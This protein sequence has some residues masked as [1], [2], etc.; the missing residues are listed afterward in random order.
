MLLKSP[1][2][3]S[4]FE[5]DGTLTVSGMTEDDAYITINVDGKPVL[6]QKTLK[7]IKATMGEEGDFS[8]DI[9]IGKG[10]YKKEVEVIVSDEIGN[11]QKAQCEVFN[12]GMGNVKSLDVALSADTTDNT[13]KE[14]ISYSN[15]N[16]FLS[17]K[18]DTSVAMQLCAITNDNN[19]I[20]LN[21]MENVDWNMKAVLGSA[22]MDSNKLTVKKGSHGFVE[23]KLILVDGAALSTSFTFGAEVQGQTQEKGYKVIYKANGGKG[24]MTDPNSPYSKNDSVLVSKCGFTYQGK[25][26]VSWNTKADGSGTTYVPGDKFYIKGDVTLYAIWKKS[27]GG[28]SVKPGDNSTVKVGSTQT[29]GKAK[30]RV[31]FQGAVTYLGTT[32]KKA[33]KLTIPDT[34]KIKGK[35]YKVTAVGTNVA[36]SNKKLTSVIIGKNVTV[37]AAKAFY[38]KKK[39]KSIKFKSSKISKIG[40]YAF[41]GISK[42]AVFKVPKKAKKKYKK[43]L[44]KKT[45]FVKKTMKLK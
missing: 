38:K 4:G 5:E 1:T 43:K 24:A 42:K 28:D 11:T 2:K 27:S 34:I 31:T 13:E 44:S 36:K 29:V 15:K 41:K 35:T 26:F 45:G 8:F 39:L 10:Y 40:K 7:D 3:G 21:G 14:W 25:T 19:T 33:K 22:E 9:N 12:N 20:V 30:Y 37:I 32:D 6:R 16:L 18:D 23:G 17:D